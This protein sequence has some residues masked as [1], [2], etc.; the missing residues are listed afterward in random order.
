MPYVIFPIV[1]HKALNTYNLY[2][3][4]EGFVFTEPSFYYYK[5]LAAGIINSFPFLVY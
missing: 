4:I 2:I 5:P 1:Q 3:N